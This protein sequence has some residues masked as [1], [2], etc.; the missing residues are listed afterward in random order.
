MKLC[1]PVGTNSC[2]AA[3]PSLS[4]ARTSR[5]LAAMQADHPL[6]FCQRQ[7]GLVTSTMQ[8]KK[9]PGSAVAAHVPTGLARLG[10]L[11]LNAQGFT[12]DESRSN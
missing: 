1:V 12:S 2:I 3:L 4:A 10:A 8:R 5:N 11:G 7:T 9:L 6:V